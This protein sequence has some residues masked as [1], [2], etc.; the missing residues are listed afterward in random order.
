MACL[1]VPSASQACLQRQGKNSRPSATDMQHLQ[2]SN[3]QSSMALAACTMRLPQTQVAA[4]VAVAAA[5]AAV[6]DAAAGR[7]DK[8]CAVGLS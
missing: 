4:A 6:A 1:Q 5:A 2:E 3:V 8:H 7:M